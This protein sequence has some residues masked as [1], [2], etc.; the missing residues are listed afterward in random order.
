MT[1]D[2][3][4]ANAKGNVAVGAASGYFFIGNKEQYEDEIDKLHK[5][6]V[7]LAK[8]TLNDANKRIEA[9][10]AGGFNPVDVFIYVPQTTDPEI[11]KG[12]FAS[13]RMAADELIQKAK[14]L[15]NYTDKYESAVK[16]KTRA[17]GIINSMPY[18]DRRVKE[19][20]KS[21][22]EDKTIVIIEGDESGRFWDM[23]EAER[24]RDDNSKDIKHN[25]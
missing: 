25:A 11:L 21:I 20:Y 4:M 3:F 8:E 2:E 15:K 10:Q 17:E 5:R 18:R 19:S 22:T 1:L 24:S 6:A 16:S 7:S 9:L 13:W 14:L 23:S 12:S